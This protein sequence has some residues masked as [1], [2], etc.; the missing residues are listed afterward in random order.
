MKEN[1]S[2]ETISALVVLIAINELWILS[3]KFRF[4][5]NKDIAALQ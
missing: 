1:L 5:G 4:L 3:E 2:D